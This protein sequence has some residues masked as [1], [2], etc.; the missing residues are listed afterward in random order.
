MRRLLLT[1]L[2]WSLEDFDVQGVVVLLNRWAPSGKLHALQ[3]CRSV[4]LLSQSAFSYFL[5]FRLVPEGLSLFYCKLLSRQHLLLYTVI[6]NLGVTVPV[7]GSHSICEVS[8]YST[9]SPAM[10]AYDV[11][12]QDAWLYLPYKLSTPKSPPLPRSSWLNGS[13]MLPVFARQSW[14]YK[15]FS[16]CKSASSIAIL[17]AR[18]TK[19]VFCASRVAEIAANSLSDVYRQTSRSYPAACIAPVA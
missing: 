16:F 13:R 5:S 1:G 15:A 6:M 17:F 8:V 7:D 14:V 9:R 4:L 11:F 10:M 2:S 19:E 3:L 12:R 18:A